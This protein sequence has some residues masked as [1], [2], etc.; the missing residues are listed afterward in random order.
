MYF[1]IQR[2]DAT[3]DVKTSEALAAFCVCRIE[4]LR[5]EVAEAERRAGQVSNELKELNDTLNAREMTFEEKA[6]ELNK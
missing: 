5:Q 4:Q 3:I 1:G 6:A 2:A